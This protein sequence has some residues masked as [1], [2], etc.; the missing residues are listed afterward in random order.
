MLSSTKKVEEIQ[1]FA[2]WTLLVAKKSHQLVG[3]DL[4]IL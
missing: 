1:V 2:L 3:I 4:L